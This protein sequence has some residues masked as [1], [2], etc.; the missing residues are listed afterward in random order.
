MRMKNRNEGMLGALFAV[1]L[2]VSLVAT[3]VVG[4]ISNIVW[5]IKQD[6][7]VANGEVIISILGIILTPLGIIHGIYTWF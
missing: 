2:G 7:L 6:V 1:L 4:Y 3:I 5:L